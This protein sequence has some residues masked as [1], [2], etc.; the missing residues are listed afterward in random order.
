VKVEVQYRGDCGTWN[1][2]SRRNAHNDLRI[3]VARDFERERTRQFSKELPVDL[4]YIARSFRLPPWRHVSSAAGDL[5]A[6][7][8]APSSIGTYR[9]RHPGGSAV[10]R[11]ETRR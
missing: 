3:K 7:A 4:E 5:L 9:S 11:R 6:P 8:R 1:Y 2:A 10:A